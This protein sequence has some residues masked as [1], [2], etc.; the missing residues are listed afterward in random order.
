MRLPLIVLLNMNLPK[1]GPGYLD[2]GRDIDRPLVDSA[3]S[4]ADGVAL[5]ETRP[6]PAAVRR[7]GNPDSV[8][9]DQS[10]ATY[11]GAMAYLQGPKLPASVDLFWNQGYFDAHLEYPIESDRWSSRSG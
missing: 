11:D 2:L 1:R 10:F 6:A 9:S 8:P 4:F 3:R 7:Q 5:F